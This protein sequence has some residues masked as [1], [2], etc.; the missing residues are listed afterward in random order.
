MKTSAE[1]QDAADEHREVRAHVPRLRGDLPGDLVGAHGRL[2]EALL[3]AEEGAAEDEG[4]GDAEPH[5]DERHD[6]AEGHGA[7]RAA[8]PDEEVEEERADEDDARV[9]EG[10]E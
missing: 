6:R 1:G 2:E 3:E 7:R 10:G 4:D 5:A 8:A 9:E